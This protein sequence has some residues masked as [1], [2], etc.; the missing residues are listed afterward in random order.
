LKVS[1]AKAAEHRAALLAAAAALLKEQGFTGASVA[2]ISQKAGLTQA[3][4]YRHFESKAAFALEANRMSHAD[5]LAAWRALRGA[6]PGDVA[7][8]LDAYLSEEHCRDVAAGC[9]MAAYGRRCGG[10]TMRCKPPSRRGSRTQCRCC[11]TPALSHRLP[12]SAARQRALLLVSSLVGSMAVARAVETSNPD[13]AGEI[14]Q[15]AR[16][17]LRHLAASEGAAGTGEPA[18]P[19]GADP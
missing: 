12:I 7:A 14:L 5:D 2:E 1:K 17:E 9:P 4:F 15:A 19:V 18:M 11:R 8:H 3:A 16:D 13:L 6:V 10:R